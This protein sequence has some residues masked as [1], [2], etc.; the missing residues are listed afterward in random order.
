[1]RNQVPRKRVILVTCG[2]ALCLLFALHQK[3][4]VSSQRATTPQMSSVIPQVQQL[5][6]SISE[7]QT[8]SPPKQENDIKRGYNP[9]LQ[10]IQDKLKTSQPSSSVSPPRVASEANEIELKRLRDRVAELE[11]EANS[12]KLHPVLFDTS[13]PASEIGVSAP[14]P[15]VRQRHRADHSQ[16]SCAGQTFSKRDARDKSCMYMNICFDPNVG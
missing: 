15:E 1:M 8:S 10:R 6:S 3:S 16:H 7:L 2:V 13:S 14:P 5:K 11:D 4:I 9:V 12:T